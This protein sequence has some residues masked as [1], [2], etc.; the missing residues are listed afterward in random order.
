MLAKGEAV[1]NHAVTLTLEEILNFGEKPK[2]EETELE[3]AERLRR[4]VWIT[5]HLAPCVRGFK[6][7]R[8][9]CCSVRLS[10]TDFTPSDEAF[11]K[12]ACENMWVKWCRQDSADDDD[13]EDPEV[14]KRQRRAEKGKYTSQGSN[15]KFSGWSGEGIERYNEFFKMAVKRRAA[16]ATPALEDSVKDALRARHFK[17]VSLEEIRKERTRARKR[18]GVPL[19]GRLPKV[20]RD[21]NIIEV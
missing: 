2:E 10:E 6:E 3:A 15:R 19:V 5:E 14:R 11:L 18:G 17:S 9:M 12:V 20:M 8:Q 16:A 1:P 7:W 21:V 13:D 4:Q